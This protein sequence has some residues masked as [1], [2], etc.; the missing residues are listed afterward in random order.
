[1]KTA[2]AQFDP[3][4]RP[5][6]APVFYWDIGPDTLSFDDGQQTS[7]DL[8]LSLKGPATLIGENPFTLEDTGGVGAVWVRTEPEKSGR[9]LLRADHPSLGSAETEITA[10]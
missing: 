6:I 2:I 9:I 10:I 5:V 3:R 1:M 7:G 4:A 8:E